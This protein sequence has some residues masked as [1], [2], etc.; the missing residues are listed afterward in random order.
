M[1]GNNRVNHSPIIKIFMEDGF[2]PNVEGSLSED[3]QTLL[4]TP[5]KIIAILVSIAGLFI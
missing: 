2:P 1:L 4:I 5:L 3:D